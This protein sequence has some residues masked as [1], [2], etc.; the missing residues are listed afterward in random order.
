M[1]ASPFPGTGEVPNIKLTVIMEEESGK[2]TTITGKVRDLA[3]EI[4]REN[5]PY[6]NGW[7]DEVAIPFTVPGKITHWIELKAEWVTEEDRHYLIT[8]LDKEKRE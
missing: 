4:K 3:V 6:G 5:E 1:L 8:V 2:V 7:I